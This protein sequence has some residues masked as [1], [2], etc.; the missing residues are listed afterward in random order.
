[1]EC[2]GEW[3]GPGWVWKGFLTDGFP[4]EWG[5]V[6]YYDQGSYDAA[7]FYNGVYYMN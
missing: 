2:H 5:G 6:P 7:R 3:K 4:M 1:M